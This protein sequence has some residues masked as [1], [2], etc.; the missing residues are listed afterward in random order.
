MSKEMKNALWTLLSKISPNDR[1]EMNNQQK[2]HQTCEE[3][4]ATTFNRHLPTASA[5]GEA[6][7]RP[8]NV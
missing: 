7:E 6:R 2:R 5:S 3:E 4:I 1:N 8:G